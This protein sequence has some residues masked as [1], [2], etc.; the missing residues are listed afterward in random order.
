MSL[1]QPIEC[2]NSIELLLKIESIANA[3][4]EHGHALIQAWDSEEETLL[5][6]CRYLGDVQYHV[7]SKENGVV[8]V[9]PSKSLIQ[10]I[11]RAQYLGTGSGK[12]NPHTDGS[13]LNGLLREEDRLVRVLPPKMIVLQ[14]VRP[15]AQGGTNILVDTEMIFEELLANE[16]QHLVALLQEDVMTFCRDDRM[17]VDLPMFKRRADGRF[18]VRYR[19]DAMAYVKE[20]AYASI[21]HVQRNYIENERFFVHAALG[22]GQI[23]IVDNLRVLHGREAILAAPENRKRFLRRAWLADESAASLVNVADQAVNQ[24]GFDG[25][26]P[27]KRKPSRRRFDGAVEPELGIKLDKSLIE[28]L[29]RIAVGN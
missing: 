9:T 6:V 8:D 14:C 29:R 17:A 1:Q 7:R 2:C 26:L 24:R 11:D 15:A 20:W 10:P 28:K 19:F 4:T 13:Y 25:Y 16:P 12:F 23:L 3:L 27:Y 21:L 22:E 18:Q 5:E